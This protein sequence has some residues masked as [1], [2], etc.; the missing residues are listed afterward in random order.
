MQTKNLRS[1]AISQLSFIILSGS[2]DKLTRDN[3]KQEI[4]RRF[5][6]NG[7]E[8]DAFMEYEV[9][10]I[11]RRGNNIDDYLIA[12]YPSSQLYMT[13]FYNLVYNQS[14]NEH[15]NLL[16]SEVL[17]CNEDN[18]FGLTRKLLSIEYNNIEKR[19]SLC[20]NLSESELSQFLQIKDIIRKR[21]DKKPGF[22][23]STTNLYMD[24]CHT[25]S[26]LN[27]SERKIH[28]I[29][30]L[31]SRYMEGK[32]ILLPKLLLNMVLC[33]NELLDTIYMHYLGLK[34]GMHLGK[35]KNILIKSFKNGESVNYDQVKS[36][37]KV[38]K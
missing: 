6:E 30:L 7:C 35:Q 36:Y 28:E 14:W 12:E 9:D 19:I 8:Y 2:Y 34:E 29:E 23:N 20:N 38:K 10:V 32:K 37:S 13:L 25:S 16:F 24:I 11:A 22:E 3:A 4:I 33:D 1:L 31:Y 18:Y 21:L 26:C 5:S 17:M 15:S 27:G